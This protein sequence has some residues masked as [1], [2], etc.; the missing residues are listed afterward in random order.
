MGGLKKMLI[1]VVHR[2]IHEIRYSIWPPLFFSQCHVC[3]V[4]TTPTG[5]F[6]QVCNRREKI[7][8]TDNPHSHST[9]RS[10]LVR[11]FRISY[12]CPWSFYHSLRQKHTCAVG[13]NSG[14]R[15][16]HLSGFL[17]DGC[18][19]SIRCFQTVPLAP[20]SKPTKQ[21][22]HDGFPIPRFLSNIKILSAPATT[23]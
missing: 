1:G 8:D 22:E 6:G 20:S 5:A 4:D 19:F 14:G 21:K 16:L 2:N 7:T 18:V 23:Y 9:A 3:G 12:L 15:G 17:Y 10:M 13:E 11:I